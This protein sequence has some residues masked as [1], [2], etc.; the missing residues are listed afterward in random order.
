MSATPAEILA[1]AQAN[2]VGAYS[3]ARWDPLNKRYHEWY[4][5]GLTADI[6]SGIYWL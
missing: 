2:P 1:W 4:L 6:T 3:P 5:F